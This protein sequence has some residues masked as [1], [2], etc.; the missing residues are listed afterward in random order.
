MKF[1]GVF[2][3][4]SMAVLVVATPKPEIIEEKR[5]VD[6]IISE[7]TSLAASVASEVT[8][9]VGEIATEVT[10]IGGKV[11]TE[12]TSVG[13]AAITLAESGAGVVTTFAGS[14]YT[15]ATAAAASAASSATQKG[16]GNVAVAN[17]L[18]F[19]ISAPALAALG[20]TAGG[21][22]FGA[23]VAF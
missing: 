19:H 7:A 10:S 9:A 15:V 1:T 6:S 23:W 20:T 5:Q 17:I 2:A 8:S 16:S 21:I 4:L 18:P 3:A 11:F 12:I 13:G 14:V 22:L